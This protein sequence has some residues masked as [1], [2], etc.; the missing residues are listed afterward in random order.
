MAAA[1]HGMCELAVILTRIQS[2]RHG[3]C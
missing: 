1:R 3:R 2:A